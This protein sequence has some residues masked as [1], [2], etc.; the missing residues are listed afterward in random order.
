MRIHIK[1]GVTTTV[2]TL[3]GAGA[4]GAW[5]EQRWIGIALILSACLVLAFGVDIDGLRV[6]SSLLGKWPVGRKI[7]F[8]D[9]ARLA[10]EAMERTGLDDMTSTD[11]SS[12]EVN[13]NHFKYVFLSAARDGK[14][15]LYG[16]RPPSTQSLQIPVDLIS[17]L[18][19]RDSTSNLM[20][21]SAASP[22]TFQEVTISKHDLKR[23]I[24]DR[25][26][27]LERVNE[28]L[29]RGS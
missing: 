12:P 3:A 9:A 7:L 11:Y 27:L 25:I 20:S 24:R 19:P 2:L 23:L 14:I 1:P 15:R 22:L 21:L 17:G 8:H 5:Q 6:R 16:K 10:Y 28:G 13:L 4:L 29:S 26:A 18:K